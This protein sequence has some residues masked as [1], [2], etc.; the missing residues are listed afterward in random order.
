MQVPLEKLLSLV[1][2]ADGSEGSRALREMLTGASWADLQ[3]ISHEALN[4]KGEQPAFAL[5]GLC[6]QH[7]RFSPADRRRTQSSGHSTTSREGSLHLMSRRTNIGSSGTFTYSRGKK[8]NESS[9]SRKAKK[10]SESTSTC[11]TI[12]GEQSRTINR[13]LSTRQQFSK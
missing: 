1:K 9:G 6:L 4:A 12:N 2:L 3:G 13:R 11:T 5:S 8:A 10:V 7:S